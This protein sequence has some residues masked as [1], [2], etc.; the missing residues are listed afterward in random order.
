M[1]LKTQTEKKEVKETDTDIRMLL[2]VWVQ[3]QTDH[4]EKFLEC[5]GRS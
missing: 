1:Y 2:S 5:E 3:L 4:K